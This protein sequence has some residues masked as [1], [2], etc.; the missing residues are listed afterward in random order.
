MSK[1]RKPTATEQKH[2]DFVNFYASDDPEETIDMTTLERGTGKQRWATLGVSAIILLSAIAAGLGYMVFSDNRLTVSPSEVTV[3]LKT[4]LN[5]AQTVASGDEMTLTIT[6]KNNSAVTLT[7]GSVELVEPDGFYAKNTTKQWDISDLVP[8][9]SDNITVTGQ[10]LGKVGDTKDFTALLTYTP[11]NFA[12]NFQ[13]SATTSITV[14]ESIIKVDVSV[15]EQ[16]RSA[17]DMEYA[18]TITNSA[19]LSL[20]NTKAVLQFPAG[21]TPTT[22]T[23][24]WTFDEIAANESRQIKLTGTMDTDAAEKQEFVLQVGI[25]EPDGFLNLQAEDRHTVKVSNP[26]LALSLSGPSS[27]AAGGQLDYDIKVSNPSKTDIKEVQLQLDFS[28]NAVEASSA[29]LDTIATLAPGD[30][31][32]LSYQAQ[33]KDNIPDTTSAITATLSIGQAKVDDAE[34]EFTTTADVTTA[35]QGEFELSAAARYF[36][37]DL[38]KLGSGPI[39]PQVGETTQYV[40][41]WTLVSGGRTMTDLTI[42]TT[43]P[44]NV[45]FVASSANDIAYD[46]STRTVTYSGSAATAQFTVSVTPT[47]TDVDKLMILTHEAIAAA[48]DAASGTVVQAQAKKLTTHLDTDPG[49]TDDGIVVK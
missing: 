10:V 30:E 32:T 34:V 16:V 39:P 37:D 15:P 36:A 41:M 31:Q 26:E 38:T 9:A 35:V 29:T 23:S 8:G 19:S 5:D 3:A 11:Q 21:F 33:V 45:E 20:V 17:E 6:Y 42:T 22:Q 49:A 47:K 40:I 25:Q 7:T 46:S 18:F 48:T 24:E 2:T 14:G 1:R 27:V 12:S 13:T 28:G 43:L 44:D 4:D